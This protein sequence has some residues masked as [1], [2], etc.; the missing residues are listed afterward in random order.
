MLRDLQ[1]VGVLFAL[2]LCAATIS[3][4]YLS[5]PSF[6]ILVYQCYLALS[7]NSCFFLSYDSSQHLDDTL[8][9]SMSLQVVQPS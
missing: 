2:F 7:I 1:V 3:G 4:L 6:S 8:S 9:H 5:F